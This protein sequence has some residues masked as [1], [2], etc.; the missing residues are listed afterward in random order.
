MGF[1]YLFKIFSVMF[2]IFILAGENGDEDEKLLTCMTYREVILCMYMLRLLPRT[3]KY[4]TYTSAVS[5]TLGGIR[6]VPLGADKHH[7][8]LTDERI[9]NRKNIHVVPSICVN[10]KRRVIRPGPSW[11]LFYR[12]LY[13]VYASCCHVH[14]AAPRISITNLF[15]M[16]IKALLTLLHD[17]RK[18]LFCMSVTPWSA[19]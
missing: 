19:C 4:L 16:N 15:M 11:G 12:Y 5:F 6:E 17:K 18:F 3:Q 13:I 2:T 14:A 9:L 1:I 10:S 7:T 8:V